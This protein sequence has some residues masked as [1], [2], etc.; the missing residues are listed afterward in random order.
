MTL[1]LL[2][3]Y[4]VTYLNKYIFSIFEIF[5]IILNSVQIREKKIIGGGW[6][7]DIR[8]VS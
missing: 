4:K 2:I 7:G 3:V 1:N 6:S 5:S 8:H